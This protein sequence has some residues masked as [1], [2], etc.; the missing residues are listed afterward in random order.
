MCIYIYS[1]FIYL[2]ILLIYLFIYLPVK[3]KHNYF[4]SSS[5]KTFF[6]GKVVVITPGFL[7]SFRVKLC[8]S[9]FFPVNQFL[10]VIVSDVDEWLVFLFMVN[11]AEV[12]CV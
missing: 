10:R 4:S 2:F 1:L 5:Q 9:V 3:P 7:P 6:P 11:F 12:G 8:F